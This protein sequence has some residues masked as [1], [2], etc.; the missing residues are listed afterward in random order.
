MKPLRSLFPA[1]AVALF[2]ASPLS[3]LAASLTGTVTNQTLNKPAVGDDVVLMQLQGGMTETS[4]T[5]TDAKGHFTFELPDAGPHLIRVEHQKGSY[6]KQAPPGTQSVEIDVF[7]V[8]PKVEGISTEA[9]VVRVEADNSGLKITENYFVKNQS[10]PPRTQFSDHAYEIYLPADAKIE[11]SAAMAPNG[12]PVSSS[13]VPLGDKGHY[14]FAFPIRPGETRFQLSY[15]LPYTGSYKF[16]VRQSMAAD[17]VAIMLPKS[18][19][20][21]PANA[22]AFQPVND[23]VT[24]Q[25]FLAKNVAPGQPLEFTVSGTGSMP[26]EAQGADSQAGGGSADGTGASM[27][28]PGAASGDNRPGGGLGV[29]VGGEDPINKYRWW[30]L[31]GLSMV[32]AIAAGFLLRRPST[33]PV[34]A[35][36]ATSARVTT[37]SA[38]T[39][40][41]AAAASQNSTLAALKDELFALETER[42]EGHLSDADYA[43]LKGAL[44][45]VLRRAL[46]RQGD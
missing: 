24:A 17:N 10:S 7:D 22:A 25:T 46:A 39:P 11:G 23:D 37:A 34:P 2:L 16:T 27:P 8:A 13:P 45:T 6:F 38:S 19:K 15:S 44:E 31:G 42:L 26:R 14:A 36:S 28:A 21:T 3:S 1:L 9:D 40:A 35:P 12:M 30:I 29:P 18:M 41:G 5:K 20:F 32:L 4:R 33:L 43:K